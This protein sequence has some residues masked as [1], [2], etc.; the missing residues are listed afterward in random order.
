MVTSVAN[1]T[2]RLRML[3]PCGL[4]PSRAEPAPPGYAFG[5][6]RLAARM[7]DLGTETAFDVLARTRVLEAQGKHVLHL[8]IGEPDFPTPPHVVEAGIRALKDGATKYGPPPGLPQL[9]EA[10]C[11]RVLADV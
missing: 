1:A 4:R 6:A 2:P 11:E 9:R 7:S 10:V 3:R 5:M 8:E